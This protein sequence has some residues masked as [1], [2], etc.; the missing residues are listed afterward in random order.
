MGHQTHRSE[1]VLVCLLVQNPLAFRYLDGI[2]NSACDI[3]IIRQER[4]LERE[5]SLRC[6]PVVFVIDEGVPTA[7]DQKRLHLLRS[8]FAGARILALGPELPAGA[9]WHS[10]AGLDGF[11]TYDRVTRDLVAAI[12]AVW[13]GHL[14]MPR[15]VVD[16]FARRGLGLSRSPQHHGVKSLTQ[17]ELT[18]IRLVREGLSNKEAGARLGISTRTVKFHLANVFSKLGVNDRHTAI[19]VAYSADL[20]QES[21]PATDLIPK[22]PKFQLPSQY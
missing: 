6:L 8:T 18:V 2:L 17:R 13:R 12:R 1:H 4:V 15:H 5:S 14:W 20:V 19:D 16:Q 22:A 7:P 21:S 11:V 9:S 3:A 10:L